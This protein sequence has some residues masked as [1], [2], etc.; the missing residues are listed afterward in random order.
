MWLGYDPAFTGDRAALAIIAPPKVEGGDYRVLHWQTFH[1][2][3]Y[4][5]QASRIKSFCDDYNVT[6]IVI[7]KTGMGSGVFQ[8]VK[9]FYP[10]AIGLDYNADLKNEMVLKTQNL[11]QK[12]RLKFDGNE[13]ITSFMTVKKRITGT[14][15]ITYVSDRSEDAS[16]GDLSWAIMNCIL[17]VPYGLNGDVSN[18]QSTIFT[19]E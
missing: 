2:M 18:N 15:K 7:D 11:I 8:E 4:E 3:D 13:I 9:K 5:A 16:H 6:R 17:N 12:R 19:F 1:G 14:G 10:M